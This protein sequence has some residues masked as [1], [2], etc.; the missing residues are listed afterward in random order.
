MVGLRQVD[1]SVIESARGMGMTKTAVLT[2]IELPL[3]VL[4]IMAGL[5]TALTISEVVAALLLAP[6]AHARARTTVTTTSARRPRTDHYLS[7][8]GEESCPE[9]RRGGTC[10]AGCVAGRVRWSGLRGPGR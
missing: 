5:R 4:I 7:V 2:R 9:V 1:A 3:A 8:F 10:S 6:V